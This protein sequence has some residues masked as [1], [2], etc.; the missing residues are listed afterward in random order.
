MG[1]ALG[2]FGAYIASSSKMREYLINFCYG[3]IYSTA[4]PPSVIGSMDAAL[5]L[6][7]TMDKERHDLLSKAAVFRSSLNE[8]G[9]NTGKSTTQIIPVIIGDEGDA[10]DL[11]KWLEDNNILTMTF[12]YPTVAQGES[13]IRISLSA[14]HTQEHLG[15][16]IDLFKKWRDK[17]N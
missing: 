3:L 8:L 13:R 1:K 2:S 15:R 16:V 9:Y 14:A 6:I 10:M 7:P 5:E 4:L 17:T 12:R 11:S